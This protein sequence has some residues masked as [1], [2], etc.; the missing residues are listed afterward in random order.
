MNQRE[1]KLKEL[2]ARWALI[3]E[4][5]GSKKYIEAELLKKG[6]FTNIPS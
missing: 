3:Q 6:C 1:E 2:E 4:A 5:G